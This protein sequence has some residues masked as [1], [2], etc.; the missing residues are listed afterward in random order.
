MSGLVDV[1]I[2]THT[3]RVALG[4]ATRVHASCRRFLMPTSVTAEP[5]FAAKT[6]TLAMQ[7]DLL[8]AQTVVE[9][10]RD[11]TKV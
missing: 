6:E 1:W 2:G 5:S 8:G 10:A 3:F 4:T 11:G 7:D 9:S